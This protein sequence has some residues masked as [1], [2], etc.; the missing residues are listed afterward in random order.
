M[1][2]ILPASQRYGRHL[3]PMSRSE[4]AN[5]GGG[6]GRKRPF[7]W[8]S[9]FCMACQGIS[10]PARGA[11]PHSPHPCPRALQWGLRQGAEPGRRQPPPPGN[12]EQ[13]SSRWDRGHVPLLA[14]RP[15]LHCLLLLAPAPSISA[16]RARTGFISRKATG[17]PP[18][19][20]PLPKPCGLAAM[21][22]GL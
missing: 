8:V 21:P 16:L 20:A 7:L 15:A 2:C 11:P 3:F 14:G 22:A 4:E 6:R 1:T 19:S 13:I 5:G 9:S 17:N 10:P 18:S 12:A